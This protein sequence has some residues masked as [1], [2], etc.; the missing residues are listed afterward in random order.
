MFLLYFRE[1]HKYESDLKILRE[2]LDYLRL[3]EEE[4]R[5]ELEERLNREKKESM[6]KSEERVKVLEKEKVWLE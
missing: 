4:K 5:Q 6:R 2:K 1:K 3:A